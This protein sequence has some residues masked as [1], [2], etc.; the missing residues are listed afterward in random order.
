MKH[1]LLTDSLS[2]QVMF[3]IQLSTDF[4]TG[5]AAKAGGT[6]HTRKN[7]NT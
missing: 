7:M 2:N 6:A 4:L 3:Y 1:L 5:L